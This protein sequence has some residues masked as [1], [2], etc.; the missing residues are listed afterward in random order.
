MK[1]KLS[2]LLAATL[3]CAPFTAHA[4]EARTANSATSPVYPVSSNGDGAVTKGYSIS[5]WAEDWRGM[6]DKSKRDDP[7]DRLK[8]LPL[9]ADGDIYLTL[10]GEL[11]LR[12]NQTTNPNLREAE[13]QRQDISR[14]VAGRRPSCRPALALLRR[15]GACRDRRPEYRNAGHQ[16]AQRPCRPAIFRRGERPDRRARRGRALWAAGIRRWAQPAD[17]AARQQHGP[18]HPERR[19]GLGEGQGAA[20]RRLRPVAHRLWRGRHRRRSQRSRTP[21][22]R[23]DAGIRRAQGFSG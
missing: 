18:L 10:S 9:G 17:V 6:A 12:V 5:R 22:L 7:L 3:C 11:R 16:H 14:V 13:A 15:A 19:S 21:L 1:T 23:G 4:E 8:F 2:R 20:R